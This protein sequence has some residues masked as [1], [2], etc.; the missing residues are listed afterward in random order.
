MFKKVML[1]IFIMILSLVFSGC[2]RGNDA[3]IDKNNIRKIVVYKSTKNDVR[4]I[5]GEPDNIVTLSGGKENWMYSHN[6]VN[7]SIVNYLKIGLT[8]SGGSMIKNKSTMLNLVFNS[9]DV[10]ISKKFGY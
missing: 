8:G 5:L 7:F 6:D 10:L 4:N 1:V 3:I 2:I 9:S